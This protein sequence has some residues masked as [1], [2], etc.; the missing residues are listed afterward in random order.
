MEQDT[1]TSEPKTAK[2]KVA[3]WIQDNL[4]VIISIIIVVIIAGGIYSYSKRAEKTAM[5]PKDRAIIAEEVKDSS[6]SDDTKKSE[7]VIKSEETE[8]TFKETAIPGDSMTKLAR[9]A[10][11]NYLKNNSSV[12][13][14]AAQKIYAEDYVRKQIAKQKVSTGTTIEFSKDSVK[15]GVEKATSL[16]EN[17]LNNLQK[18]VVRVPSLT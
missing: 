2:E 8:N 14:N 3:H 5:L 1:M 7:V 13:L 15:T 18:Y 6:V 4:R 9:R 10:V 11:A 17:Q 16:T 12:S